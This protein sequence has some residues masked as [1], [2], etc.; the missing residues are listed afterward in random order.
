MH[1]W[2]GLS[3]D[4]RLG[5]LTE[6]VT[7]E[8]VDEV[9]AECGQGR[10]KPGAVSPRFMVYFTLALALFAQD[11]Y[12]DESRKTWSG[13]WRGCTRRCRTGPRSP[14]PGSGWGRRV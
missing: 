7:P 12:D 3:D 13:R 8:L 11:S 9:L 1:P 4:V 10:V 2:V 14:G 5:A 6:W